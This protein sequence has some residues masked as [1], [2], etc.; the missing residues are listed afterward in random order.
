M[1][2][3]YPI[4]SSD[5]ASSLPEPSFNECAP[6]V[7]YG[8]ISKLYIG[9]ANSSDFNN[10]N[11][12]GEWNQRLA[13]EISENNAIRSFVVLGD[14]PE[15]ENTE[16]SI[17]KN[18]TIRA[19]KKFTLSFEIDEDNDANYNS[20]LIFECGSKFKIWFETAEGILYGGNEGI[21][22]SL[23]TNY[24]IPR[25]RQELRKIIG[26]AVWDSEKSPLRCTSPFSA[27]QGNDDEGTFNE[28]FGIEFY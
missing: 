3:T 1:I 15:P 26:K 8:E 24:F 28:I 25:S 7:G 16:I 4:C 13:L 14:L 20:H 11:L 19:F 23:M 21:S 5:C 2:L 22:A 27:T 12:I 17:S 10:V 18:R 9:K 6:V